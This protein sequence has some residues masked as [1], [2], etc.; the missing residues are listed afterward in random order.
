MFMDGLKANRHFDNTKEYTQ[1]LLLLLLLTKGRA[2]GRQFSRVVK[3]PL[4][5]S[6][7]HQG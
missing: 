6:G 1:L 7:V 2:S 4:P 5:N 3:V